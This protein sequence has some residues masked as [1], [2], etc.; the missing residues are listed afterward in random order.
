MLGRRCNEKYVIKHNA[1]FICTEMNGLSKKQRLRGKFNC[2]FV[3][4]F[5][6]QRLRRLKTEKHETTTITNAKVLR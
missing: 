4:R 6:S 1:M 2:F 3:L 5:N